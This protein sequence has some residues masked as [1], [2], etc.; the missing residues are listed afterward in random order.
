MTLKRQVTV[1]LIMI[2]GSVVRSAPRP[3]RS[4]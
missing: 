4:S 1:R 3:R 2:D